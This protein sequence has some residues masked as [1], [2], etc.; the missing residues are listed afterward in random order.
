MYNR[1]GNN[2]IADFLCRQ[3][4][5]EIPE[6]EENNDDLDDSSHYVKP[7]LTDT[8]EGLSSCVTCS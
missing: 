2:S 3:D 5:N 7:K 8:Q 1:E 4:E 6:E